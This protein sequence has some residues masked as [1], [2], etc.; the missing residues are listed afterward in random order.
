MFNS[1]RK[2]KNNGFEPSIIFDIGAHHGNWTTECL[3]LYPSSK[4]HLFEGINYGE[5]TKF[6]SLNNCFVYNVILSESNQDV[7]WY[8]MQNTGDSFFKEKSKH[9]INCIPTIRTTNTLTNFFE[10]VSF[11]NEH[12]FIKIDTQGSEI[13]I[14]KGISKNILQYTDFIILELPLFGQYNDEVPT[15]LEHIQ[16][17]DSIG[18][19]PYDISDIHNINNFTMQIDMLFINKTH[20]FNIIVQDRLFK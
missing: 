18:F 13:P 7:K 20:K 10:N 3:T 11:E 16:F 17:M 19:I 6:K 4:Y 15:F 1:I 14:L 8:E 9:F 12:I 2:L 5:L